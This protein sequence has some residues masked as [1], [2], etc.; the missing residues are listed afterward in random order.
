M[1]TRSFMA[2]ALAVFSLV[3]VAALCSHRVGAA[4]GYT[5]TNLVSDQSGM[6]MNTDPN[7][8]NPWGISYSPAGPFWVSDNGTGLT[9]VYTGTGMVESIVVTIPTANGNGVGTP[10]GQVYNSTSGFVVSSG[11][12]MGAASFLFDTGDGTI[13]GW[14]AGVD[15]KNAIIAVNNSSS[16]AIYYG[17]AIGV[18]AGQTY[19]YAANFSANQ[20]EMYD[21]SF[22]L[23]NTFTD[24]KLPKGY[25]PFNVQFL[26]KY[27]VVAYGLQNSSK[28]FPQEGAG[29]GYVDVFNPDGSFFRTE[30]SKGKLNAPWGLALAPTGFG[31]F[32]GDLL[33]G[34]LGDGKINA[35]VPKSKAFAGQIKDGTGKV[36]SIDGLWALQVGNGGSGGAKNAIYFTAGPDEYQHGLLGS[37]TAN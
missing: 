29:L 9:T 31:A 24:P 2:F 25:A 12:H 6:A 34:N 22:N 7:L 10:T 20:I 15:A 28:T 11:G 3:A 23:V 33:V 8:V 21:S 18:N 32:S 16:G 37:L 27:V 4:S 26:S 36:I 30:V 5:Q 13:S 1:K 19:L 35:Y 14:S 17:L